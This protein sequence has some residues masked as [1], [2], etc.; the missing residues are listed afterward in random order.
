MGASRAQMTLTVIGDIRAELWGIRDQGRRVPN[1]VVSVHLNVL[2]TIELP[3]I[4][5]RGTLIDGRGSERRHPPPKGTMA[6]SFV[7]A[8]PYLL[9]GEA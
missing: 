7:T 2:P 9:F 3:V 5:D 1:R 4:C 8:R 6:T